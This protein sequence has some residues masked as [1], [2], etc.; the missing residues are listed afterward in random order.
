M[1]AF[2]PSSSTASSSRSLLSRTAIVAAAFGLSLAMGSTTLRTLAGTPTA[3]PAATKSKEDIAACSRM[4]EV[5][6]DA[7]DNKAAVSRCQKKCH[8]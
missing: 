5:A 2:S 1:S 4:C 3:K 8:E 6:G 7:E